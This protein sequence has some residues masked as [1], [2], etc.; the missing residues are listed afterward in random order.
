MYIMKR[1]YLES[2]L[3]HINDKIKMQKEDF[4][5]RIKVQNR[6]L[7]VGVL[8]LIICITTTF[9][10][11]KINGL[12]VFSISLMTSTLYA[13]VKDNMKIRLD[14][15]YDEIELNAEKEACEELLKE[16]DKKEGNLC[17]TDDI[18]EFNK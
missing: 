5:F 14:R 4:N 3:Q 10:K 9:F 15:K 12:D 13:V 17:N 2:R 1:K 7:I 18:F 6:I 16:L 11:D 8:F